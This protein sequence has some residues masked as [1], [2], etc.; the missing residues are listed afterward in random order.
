MKLTMISS[1]KKRHKN[2]TAI[3]TYAVAVILLVSSG[4]HAAVVDKVLAVVNDELITQSELDRLLIPIYQQYKTRYEG[5]EFILKI[6][7]ARRYLFNQMISDKLL[8][9]EARKR[10]LTITQDDVDGKMVELRS[11]FTSEDAFQDALTQEGVTIAELH[12]RLREQL[13]KDKLVERE[14]KAKVIITPADIHAYYQTNKDRFKLE[15][16]VALRSIVIKVHDESYRQQAHERVTAIVERLQQGEDFAELATLY[17]E[18]ANARDGG[19]MGHIKKGQLMQELDDVAFSLAIG[20]ISPVIE[21]RLGYHVLQVT[22]K[23][24]KQ[25]INQEDVHSDIKGL[26]YNQKTKARYEEFVDE[27]KQSAYISIK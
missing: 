6:D 25:L 17:S 24:E 18:S 12:R 1:K 21:T 20:E 10:A 7:E 9:S 26:L 15:E 5:D 27:L 2:S 19:T 16:Q 3:A 22:D 11:R 23:K 4:A 13:L 14:I 8:L